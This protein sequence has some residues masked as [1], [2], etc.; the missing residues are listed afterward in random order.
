MQSSPPIIDDHSHS[1]FLVN[2]TLKLNSSQLG[3]WRGH[4]VPVDHSSEFVVHPAESV[5]NA[6]TDVKMSKLKAQSVS[7]GL[8]VVERKNVG[9]SANEKAKLKELGERNRILE[10]QLMLHTKVGFFTFYEGNCLI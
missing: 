2:E 10:S 1:N 7:S 5:V 3:H 6:Q 4:S 8:L 9:R